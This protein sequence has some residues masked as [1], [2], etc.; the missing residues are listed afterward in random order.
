M[1]AGGWKIMAR[2][3][4]RIALRVAAAYRTASGDALSV[5]SGIPPV[6]LKAM[7]RTEIYE[8]RRTEVSANGGKAEARRKMLADWQERWAV[9]QNGGWTRCLY[10]T[11]GLGWIGSMEV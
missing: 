11:F 7:E 4:K 10:R 2:C 3:Q 5:I 8:H 1:S 9:S 6:D